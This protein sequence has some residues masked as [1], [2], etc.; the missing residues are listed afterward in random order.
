MLA[1]KIW[2][3]E[4]DVGKEYSGSRRVCIIEGKGDME[5]P[6]ALESPKKVSGYDS[7]DE[8]FVS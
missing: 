5:A 2:S 3:G 4:Q 7:A 8:V 1:I 6:L